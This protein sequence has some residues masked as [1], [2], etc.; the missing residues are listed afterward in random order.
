MAATFGGVLMHSVWQ[1]FCPSHGSHVGGGRR[2]AGRP[3]VVPA[4]GLSASDTP[5]RAPLYAATTRTPLY[6][7]TTRA[8]LYALFVSPARAGPRCQHGQLSRTLGVPRKACTLGR[9]C[10]GCGVAWDCLD[11][12][13][14]T[15]GG[16]LHVRE[17][18]WGGWWLRLVAVRV[19]FRVASLLSH[20]RGRPAAG[21]GDS[22]PPSRHGSCPASYCIVC[23]IAEPGSPH[24]RSV[25]VIL[26]AGRAGELPLRIRK[27]VRHGLP[28][29]PAGPAARPP[30]GRPVRP[31]RP[32]RGL[33]L[34]TGVQ[35]T[36]PSRTCVGAV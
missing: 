2:H 9:G 12:R 18:M 36:T 7:A 22:G 34:L 32:S 14:G 3:L 4:A 8:P 29:C 21:R 20:P 25:R 10:G 23:G 17:G 24:E 35:C 19:S 15:W 31:A 28:A 6:A 1:A 27:T 5:R 33:S 30:A 26:T 16:R 13:E 11:A